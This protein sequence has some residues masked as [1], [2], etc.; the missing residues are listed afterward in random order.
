MA[1]TITITIASASA[2]VSTGA[3]LPGCSFAGL[4]YA[5]HGYN[6]VQLYTARNVEHTVGKD[7]P[8]RLPPP[9]PLK[10]ARAI[11]TTHAYALAIST[12]LRAAAQDH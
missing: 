10:L 12:R 3:L 5:I 2:T 6:T 11:R 4:Q 1:I 7:D 9:T 8:F